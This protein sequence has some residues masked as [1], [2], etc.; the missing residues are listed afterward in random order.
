MKR[1]RTYVF[2]TDDNWFEYPMPPYHLSEGLEVARAIHEDRKR[3]E[4]INWWI[5][6]PHED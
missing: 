2:Q 1:S 5:K 3:P 4:V 6:S